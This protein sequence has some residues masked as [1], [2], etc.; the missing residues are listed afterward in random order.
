[1]IEQLQV[2]ALQMGVSFETILIAGVAVGTLILFLG[3]ASILTQKNTAAVRI[4]AANVDRR[5]RRQDR[6]LLQAPSADPRGIMKSFVPG[7]LAKR[8]ELQ[9]KLAQ[10]GYTGPSALSRFMTVRV[11]LGLVL[12][13]SLVLLIVISKTPG[14]SL[15]LGMSDWIASYSN[16]NVFQAMTLLVA[17]GYFLP[18]KWL[19][20]RV[21]ER[22]QRIREG[23]PN[24]LD[25]MQISVEAGMG[26]DAAMTRVGNELAD[27]SPGIAFEFLSVQRQVQAGRAREAA[28]KD[29]AA[30]TGVDTVRSFVNVVNQSIEY[31][32]SMSDALTAYAVEMRLYREMQAQEMANKL[33]VKMSAV[34]ASL[35]LPALILLTVGP[36]VIR[37]MRYFGA[38]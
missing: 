14:V 12:P 8:T 10:A 16:W 5:Q 21:K 13:G 32:T 17:A 7:D 31:G 4:A 6:G 23:F 11:L 30:R 37:Y 35:M 28:L 26:F 29:M 1:M 20:S 34:L 24:A 9:R 38:S 18:V 36:V 2:L 19:E 33:P 22:Q 25:L 3:V 27:V 15:P